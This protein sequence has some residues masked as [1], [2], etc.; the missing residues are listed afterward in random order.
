MMQSILDGT[1]APRH[2][3]AGLSLVE[4]EHFLQLK[5]NSQQEPLAVFSATGA[6]IE[7]IIKEADRYLEQQNIKRWRKE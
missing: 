5:H 2:R 4:D 3:D 7:E 1:L 6:T